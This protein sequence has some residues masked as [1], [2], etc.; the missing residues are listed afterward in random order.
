MKRHLFSGLLLLFSFG[1]GTYA[2]QE[3]YVSFNDNWLFT[4][5]DSHDY[6]LTT[7]NPEGWRQLDL[8]MTG[9]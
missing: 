3:K 6:S 2:S 7:Y 9:Q 4:L 5:S 8:P 1:M